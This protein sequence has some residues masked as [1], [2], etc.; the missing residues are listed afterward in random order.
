MISKVSKAA[1]FDVFVARRCGFRYYWMQEVVPR[2]AIFAKLQNSLIQPR[3]SQKKFSLFENVSFLVN[4]KIGGISERAHMRRRSAGPPWCGVVAIMVSFLILKMFIFGEPQ[5]RG[6][7]RESLYEWA[8]WGAPFVQSS[9]NHRF[10]PSLKMFIFG[11]IST[12]T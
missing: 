8:V 3:T 6:Y 11:L 5:Y 4:P 2:C 12:R 9:S 10:V 1:V 7:F